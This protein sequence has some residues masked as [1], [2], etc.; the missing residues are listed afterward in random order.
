MWRCIDKKSYQGCPPP[1]RQEFADE[2]P[3]HEDQFNNNEEKP[4]SSDDVG[5]GQDSLQTNLPEPVTDE[6]EWS[7][8]W[9]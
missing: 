4:L 2:Y 9:K 6:A 3:S 8:G 5:C 1:E 7:D